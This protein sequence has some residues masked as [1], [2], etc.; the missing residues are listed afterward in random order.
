MS[1]QAA[2]KMIDRKAAGR[3]IH[4]SSIMGQGAS[5]IHPQVGYIASKAGLNGMIRQLAIEW[6]QYGITVNGMAPGYFPTELTFDPR[7]GEMDPEFIA[8]VQ[9]L[10]PLGRVGN[11]SEIRSALLYL[12]APS[13]TYVTGSIVHVDG[14]W[15]AW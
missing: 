1:Q 14:G 13:S 5:P 8:T 2:Q 11:P 3:I 7:T 15:T 4:I 10:T 12:A 6:A 9:K